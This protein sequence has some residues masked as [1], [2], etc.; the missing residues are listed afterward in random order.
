MINARVEIQQGDVLGSLRGLLRAL[1]ERGL[2]EALLVPLATSEGVLPTLVR[3]PARLS[4]ADPL[5]P[6]LPVN[7][8]R[9][10]ASLTAT[11]N[12]LRLGAVLRP[13][14][15]RALV[16]LVKL[17][18]ASLDNAVIVGVDCLGT[19]EMTDYIALIRN[20]NSP[21]R[22]LLTQAPQGRLSPA[23]GYSFRPACRMCEFPVPGFPDGYR[24]DIVIGLIG[25][26]LEEGL[27]VQARD[28]LAERLELEDG[29]EP[30]G[31]REVVERLV[32]ERRA[33]RDRLFREF[34]EQVHDWASLAAF[35]AT[36]IRCHNCMVACPICY[37][38]ECVFRTPVFDHA[39]DRFYAWAE[40]KGAVRMPTDTLLF[41]LTR[42]NHMAT[43]C[44]GCGLCESACP[45]DIPLTTLF[46]VVG[47]R[48]QALFDY[49]PGRS[50]EE[51]VPVAVFREK[52]LEG[53]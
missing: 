32:A 25:V 45:N 51:A 30:E 36:C 2:V 11:G 14:E 4:L 12:K 53:I 49:L 8:A 38:K 33:E 22:E 42:L 47:R 46:R 24:P 39:S 21:T 50:L 3:D 26:N 16:E 7:S 44:V 5:A 23:S 37:C 20:G 9:L 13:C 48:V 28:E 10:V 31:R 29:K 43:S 34:A 1:L 17:K 52:E 19:Y 41:H 18:Q 6:V 27:L 15:I 40:R 35:F